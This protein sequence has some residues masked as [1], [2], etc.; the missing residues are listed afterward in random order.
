[1]GFC[2]SVG[3]RPPCKATTSEESALGEFFYSFTANSVT[4]RRAAQQKSSRG[5][6]AGIANLACIPSRSGS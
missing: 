2:P 1:M 5:S 3:A 6:V 4:E